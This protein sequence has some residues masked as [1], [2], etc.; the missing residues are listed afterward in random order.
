MTIKK[1]F[2][3][4]AL[5]SIGTLALAVASAS[6][7]VDFEVGDTKASVYGYAK[8][9][10]IYDVDDDMGNLITHNAI[11]ED[12]VDSQDGHFNMHAYQSRIGFKTMT[13]TSG[14]DLGK[15]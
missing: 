6:H 1:S 7:G 4:T 12:G 10:I 3:Q 11:T 14:S 8:L 5:F 15:R 13:P 9:D 2:K